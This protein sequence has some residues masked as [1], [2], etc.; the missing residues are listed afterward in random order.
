MVGVSGKGSSGGVTTP[1][2]AAWTEHKQGNLSLLQPAKWQLGS[3][4]RLRQDT[5]KT[6]CGVPQGGG[7]GVPTHLN[8]RVNHTLPK[9]H[10]DVGRVLS[11]NPRGRGAD[12]VPVVSLVQRQDG[13]G[14]Q[15]QLGCTADTVQQPT[16]PPHHSRHAHAKRARARKRIKRVANRRV[17]TCV[18]VCVHQSDDRLRTR[19]MTQNWRASSTRTAT[20]VSWDAMR[21][22]WAIPCK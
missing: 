15:G 13:A 14:E 2:N 17:C 20:S 12:G 22:A 21:S 9:L 4:Q 3:G 7:G 16:P 1:R 5:Q 11:N 10:G 18:C 8:E 19:F 6:R